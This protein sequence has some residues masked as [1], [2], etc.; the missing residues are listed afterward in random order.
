MDNPPLLHCESRGDGQS[1]P[2]NLNCAKSTPGT[3]GSYYSDWTGLDGFDDDTVEQQGTEAYCSGTSQGL[4][5]FYE[6]YP[7]APVLF[8]GADPGDALVSTTS[9][10][11]NTDRYTLAVKDITQ[12]GAGVTVVR[13]CASTCANSSAEIISEAPGGG[14]PA[15]GLSDFGAESYTNVSVTGNGVTGGLKSTSA[16]NSYAIDMVDGSN[17]KLATVGKLQGSSAFI[18]HWQNSL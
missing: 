10:N 18:D 1:R 7:A 13:S 15:Y 3:S 16:W 14:P 11:A 9:Y 8:T 17:V 6:M 4:Y 2:P 5:V 12:S